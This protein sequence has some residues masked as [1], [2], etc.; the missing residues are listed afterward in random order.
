MTAQFAK[1]RVSFVAPANLSAASATV[2]APSNPGPIVAGLRAATQWFV[3]L[4]QRR[5]VIEELSMLSDHELADI[6]LTRGEIP[7]VFDRAFVTAHSTPNAAR[8]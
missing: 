7:H 3:K 6:G 5:A 1:D 2:F 4:L 8:A